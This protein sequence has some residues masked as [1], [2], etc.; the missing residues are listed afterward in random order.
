MVRRGV[1]MASLVRTSSGF[2]PHA[3]M[4]SFSASIFDVYVLGVMDNPDAA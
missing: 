4:I 3:L 2:R 1:H